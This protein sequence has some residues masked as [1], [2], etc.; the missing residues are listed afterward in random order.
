MNKGANITARES[1]KRNQLLVRELEK[2]KAV[3]E[4]AGKET[5]LIGKEILSLINL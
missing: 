3:S 1:R 4:E 2:R 5:Y